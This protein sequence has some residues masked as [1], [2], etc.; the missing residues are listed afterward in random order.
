MILLN[1]LLIKLITAFQLTTTI[2][3]SYLLQ[4]ALSPYSPIDEEGRGFRVRQHHTTLHK[5]EGES[6]RRL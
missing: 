6:W 4:Y 3:T 5:L 2:F 1:K